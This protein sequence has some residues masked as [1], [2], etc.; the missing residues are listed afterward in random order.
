[1]TSCTLDEPPVNDPPVLPGS[2][3]VTLVVPKL[4]WGADGAWGLL[5]RAQ[6]R[7]VR[8]FAGK[9]DQL[10]KLRLLDPVAMVPLLREAS[11]ILPRVSCLDLDSC[12]LALASPD[13]PSSLV[14]AMSTSCRQQDGSNAGVGGLELGVLPLACGLSTHTRLETHVF[15]STVHACSSLTALRLSNNNLSG[16][17]LRALCGL[18]SGDHGARLRSLDLSY[19]ALGASCAA[20]LGSCLQVAAERGCLRLESLDL[21]GNEMGGGVL[22]L[23]PALE[24]MRA[25]T[26]LDLRCNRLPA[27]AS[28]SPL[29]S[30]P[31][32]STLILIEPN[33]TESNLI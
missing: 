27:G 3:R 30:T 32:Q 8:K 26:S 22:M 2:K 14:A 6:A 15:F 31:L 9:R 29:L 33:R 23:L 19:N 17:D 18:L 5:D 12:L 10:V 4:A 20:D 7:R 24:G 1:M 13:C 25:L 28:S 16:A 11:D 21:K